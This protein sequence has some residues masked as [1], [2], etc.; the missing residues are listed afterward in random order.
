M[1]ALTAGSPIIPRSVHYALGPFPAPA[2]PAILAGMAAG[3]AI[4]AS[5]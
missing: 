2:A 5:M 3:L 4:V 1:W